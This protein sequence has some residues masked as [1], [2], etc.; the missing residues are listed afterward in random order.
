MS[1]NTNESPTVSLNSIH[2]F[3]IKQIE[4]GDD[5]WNSIY[6]TLIRQQGHYYQFIYIKIIFPSISNR[7]HKRYTYFLMICNPLQPILCPGF[8]SYR[9]WGICTN[10]NQQVSMMLH[11]NYC[12]ISILSHYQH[13]HMEDQLHL[14][15]FGSI[16]LRSF[17]EQ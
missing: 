5:K 2:W 11:N 16:W 3:Q 12:H 15:K 1:G 8:E 14:Y 7:S 6:P 9:P 10:L 17:A 4:G 13:F